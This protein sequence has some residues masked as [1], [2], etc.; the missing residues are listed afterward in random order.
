[1]RFSV[2]LSGLF[3]AV[4]VAESTA[5][6]PATSVSLSPAQASQAACFKACPEG[7]VNCQAH[8]VAVCS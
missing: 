7:D 2:L 1:M 4:A 3:A 5:S 6:A 8:C